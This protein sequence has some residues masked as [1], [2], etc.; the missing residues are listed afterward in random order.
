MRGGSTYQI[1]VLRNGLDKRTR[2]LHKGTQ[3]AG[4]GGHGTVS[5]NDES[6]HTELHDGRL[7]TNRTARAQLG[8]DLFALQHRGRNG[9]R[10]ALGRFLFP[11]DF[12][13]LIFLV[14]QKKK[15]KKRVASGPQSFKR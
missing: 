2:N 11:I 12:L 3:G 13:C 8:M 4:R 1:N 7:N 6:P 14:H 9:I 5:M 15:K 10:A